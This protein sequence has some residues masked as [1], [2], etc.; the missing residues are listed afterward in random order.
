MA[1]MYSRKKGRAGSKKPLVTKPQP[2]ITHNPEE[3]EQ[4]IVKIAKSGKPASQIGLVLRDSYGIPDVHRLTSKKINQILK[5]HKLVHKI[6]DDLI[7]LIKKEIKII[8]HLESNKHD[9]P[10]RRGLSLTGSK[11]KRL[12]KYY[13]KKGV[14]SED[15][16]Y[17]RE[18]AKITI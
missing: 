7:S 6:P 15:W 12:T 17:S 10:S 11:I 16:T 8:K 18:Q 1:R 9:M 5:E 3:I 13:K 2:W 14:L 4:L